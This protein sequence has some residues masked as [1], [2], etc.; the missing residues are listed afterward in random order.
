MADQLPG[1]ADPVRSLFDAKAATWPAK[2]APDGRLAGRLAQFAS[3][4]V[5]HVPPGGRVL[6]IGCGTGNLAQAAQAANLRVTACDI[7]AE[8]LGRAAAA[9]SGGAVEWVHLDSSWLRLPFG[10]ATFD[11]VV[12]A[13]V[14]EYVG[15]PGTVLN[16]CARVLRPGGIV[17]CT[18]PDLSHP[19][20]WLEWVAGAAGRLPMVRA[21]SHRWP[22]LDGYLAYLRISRQRRPAGWW[23]AAAAR[24]GLLTIPSV[25]GPA[26]HSSLRLFTFQRPGGIGA[27]G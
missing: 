22:R 1:R 27:S 15:Q 24:A 14:L 4:L 7:S 21:V 18:V 3:A 9:D 6:D 17:L 13:S 19:V 23:C 8:M 2:Y 26:E 16:E 20:R 10:S 11:A 12:A 25:T 5:A